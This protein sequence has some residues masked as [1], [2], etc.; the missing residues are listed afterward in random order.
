MGLWPT[1]AHENHLAMLTQG[2]AMACPYSGQRGCDFQES[3]RR[4][5]IS[6]VH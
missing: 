4:G 6:A 2:H 3:R 1:R 5:R